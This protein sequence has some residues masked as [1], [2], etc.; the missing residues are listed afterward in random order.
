M[1]SNASSDNTMEHPLDGA[2]LRFERA[3]RHL[4]EADAIVASWSKAC[5][6]QIVCD[7]GK[8]RFDGGWPSIPLTLPIV[9]G[10]AIHNLR[11]ALDYIVYELALK[12]SGSVQEGTQFP[13]EDYKVHPVRR[14]RGFD[15]RVKTYLKGLNPIH[16]AMIEDLQPYRRGQWTRTLADISNRD[17]HRELCPLS[18]DGRMIGL[19][20]TY[21]SNG[22]FE[23]A[24]KVTTDDKGF[25][26]IDVERFD[27][28]IEGH[29][30]IGIAGADPTEPPIMETLRRMEME[31]CRTIELFRPE[32]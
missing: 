9:I 13:I 17:K 24:F 29:H 6:N 7:G 10:D 20:I 4:S 22:R 1:Y 21:N 5:E 27:V 26:G 32:F 28:S 8:I 23:G 18:K 16:V 14:D 3:D 19:A 30:A 25:A 31:V 2:Q 12:H 15:A 11:A